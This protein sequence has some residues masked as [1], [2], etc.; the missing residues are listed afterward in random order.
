MSPSSFIRRR[1]MSWLWGSEVAGEQER[2]LPALS[3][4]GGVILAMFVVCEV[5]VTRGRVKLQLRGQH[6]KQ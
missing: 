6:S 2:L 3:M 1:F 5:L 4:T